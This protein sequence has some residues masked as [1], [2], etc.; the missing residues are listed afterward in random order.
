MA[1]IDRYWFVKDGEIGIV[2]YDSTGTTINGV[3]SYYISPSESGTVK[4]H[5]IGRPSLMDGD[6]QD[7]PSGLAKPFHKYLVAK[8]I[9]EG[10]KDPRNMDLNNAQYFDAEFEKGVIRGRKEGRCDYKGT[11]RIVPVEF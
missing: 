2:Q 6:P 5:Y 9:A 1:T 11:G 4:V 8:V 7:E 10:Y 3:T